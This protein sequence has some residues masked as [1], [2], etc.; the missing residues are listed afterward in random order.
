MIYDYFENQLVGTLILAAD[1]QG[2]R[3]I[4]FKN[5]KTAVSIQKDWKRHP[6]FFKKVKSQL[7]A[8]FNSEL[9]EFDLPLAPE[10]TEFQKR[11]WKILQKIPYGT[12][13][14]Y[15]WVASRIGN[16]KAPRAVGGAIGKNRLAIVIP[17]HRVI[18][19]NGSLTGFGG[20]LDR[21]RRLLDLESR[22]LS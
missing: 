4:K 19:S 20:G 14:T 15:Q 2:L 1:E 6:A 12:V 9:R 3:Y 5:S 17:C 13:V 18:G 22:F 11:V 10:G 21:K 7:N 16:P 8:Y